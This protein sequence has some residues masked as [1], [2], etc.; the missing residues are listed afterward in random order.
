M[1]DLSSEAEPSDIY[2]GLNNSQLLQIISQIAWIQVYGFAGKPIP[3][4]RVSDGYMQIFY[5]MEEPAST[6]TTLHPRMTEMFEKM[7]H[8]YKSREFWDYVLR[9]AHRKLEIPDVTCHGDMWTYNFLWSRGEQNGQGRELSALLDW[10]NVHHGNPAED[11]CHLF[12]FCCDTEMRRKVEK[13]MLPI[14]HQMVEERCIQMRIPVPY[15]LE[16][17]Q[18]AYRIQLVAQTTHFVFIGRVMDTMDGL[19]PEEEKHRILAERVYGALEDNVQM[20]A[21]CLPQ[22][23]SQN[24]A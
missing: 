3:E 10:Q 14:L 11:I 7:R 1:R 15:T 24:K 19:S 16:Q 5:Q 6:W 22:F 20:L 21:E 8:L 4:I 12:V 17:L 2:N 18:A 13:E 23:V 9:I